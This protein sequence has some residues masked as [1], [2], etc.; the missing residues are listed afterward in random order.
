MIFNETTHADKRTN[1]VHFGSEPAD[2]R[3]RSRI[4]SE[5]RIWIPDQILASADIE[6]SEYFFCG[7]MLRINAAYAVMR[8][9]S[10]RLYV[11][12]VRE[13]CQNE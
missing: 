2:I 3:V 13:F 4:N 5:I 12:P 1:S 10:V 9:L 7:A 6:L 11:C 8:C